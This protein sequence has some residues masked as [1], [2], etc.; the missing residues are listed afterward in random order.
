MNRKIPYIP[1]EERPTSLAGLSRW[2]MSELRRLQRSL[3]SE[4]TRIGSRKDVATGDAGFMV[5]VSRAGTVEVSQVRIG[6]PDSGGL[7]FRALV[8]DN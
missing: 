7:G 4:I 5:V 6:A 8:I 2:V 1:V 3:D